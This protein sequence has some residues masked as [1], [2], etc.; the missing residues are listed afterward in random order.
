[1]RSRYE[2]RA[3]KELEAEGYLVDYKIRPRFPIRHYN[4]D[5]FGLFDLLAL[6]EGEGVMRCIAIKGLAGNRHLIIREIEAVQ[7]PPGIQKEIW[8]ISMTKKD[9][10]GAWK[11]RI[12]S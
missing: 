3:H 1:V 12:L 7:F 10:K 4:T 9:P 5:Y 6:K 8:W 2:I 11:K